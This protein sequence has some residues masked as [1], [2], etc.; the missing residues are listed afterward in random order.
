MEAVQR[1]VAREAGLAGRGVERPSLKTLERVGD[2][3]LHHL[4]VA[5]SA[6][7]EIQ[8]QSLTLAATQARQR[9]A[10]FAGL[11]AGFFLAAGFAS[12]LPTSRPKWR[13]AFL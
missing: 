13:S 7:D 6:S 8:I 4:G 2:N 12:N 9:R 3:A 11:A 10:F 1:P 5:T